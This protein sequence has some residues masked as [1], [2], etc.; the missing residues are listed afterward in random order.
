MVASISACKDP[1]YY[2]EVDHALYY[3][4]GDAGAGVWHGE[5][6]KFLGFTGT[7]YGEQLIAAFNGL[8]SD[9]YT[10][11]VQLPKGRN[12]Q[13][14]WDVTFSAPKSVSVLWSVL[15]ADDR[16]KIESL[17][18]QAARRAVD[19]LDS[20]ALLTRRGKGG[21][22]VEHAKG[23]YALCPHGTSRSCYQHVRPRRRHDWRHPEQGPLSAQDGSGGAFSHRAGESAGK[24]ARA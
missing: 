19:Y 20:K 14:A 18:M 12:H 2:L 16:R 13:P 9:G 11:H 5:G 4:T 8:G 3:L 15:G 24:A 1:A 7:V 10:R 22:R 17:V 21:E 23:V 6:A